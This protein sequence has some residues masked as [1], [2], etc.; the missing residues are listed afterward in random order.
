MKPSLLLD[1]AARTMAAAA[2]RSATPVSDVR[3]RTREAP[4]R[5]AAPSTLARASL[6]LPLIVMSSSACLITDPP[7]FTAPPITAPILLESTAEPSA[8]QIL[9]VDD[10]NLP[11]EETFKAQVV[12]QDDTSTMG[13]PFSQVY[14]N[15][16]IDYGFT[17]NPGGPYRYFFEGNIIGAGTINTAGRIVGAAWPP[18]VSTVSYGCHTATLV[19]SHGFDSIGCPSC[20]DDY[21]TITWQMLR[22]N[23]GAP[24]TSIDCSEFPSTGPTS[25]MSLTNSC[26]QVLADA[27][28]DASACPESVDGGAGGGGS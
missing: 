28:P 18:L 3:R 22:C 13:G 21:S 17:G 23:S 5:F 4:R 27:G 9:M 16:Y 20:A 6:A 19:A 11:E 25:C 26:A 14:A 10:V 12:S 15:L 2:V 1:L 8:N 7:Q 24:G